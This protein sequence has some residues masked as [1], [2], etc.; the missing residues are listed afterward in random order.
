MSKKY[1]PGVLSRSTPKLAHSAVRFRW[2]TSQCTSLPMTKV[3]GFTRR[4]NR[5]PQASSRP[6]STAPTATW[7]GTLT[8]VTEDTGP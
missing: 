1:P 8:T 2:W 7:R 6:P 5:S 4:M 3:P